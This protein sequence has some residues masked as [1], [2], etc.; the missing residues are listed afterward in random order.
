MSMDNL[1]NKKVLF[2]FCSVTST[3]FVG[4]C[5]YLQFIVKL[6]FIEVFNIIYNFTKIIK[7]IIKTCVLT[8]VIT[9]I[10]YVIIVL[11]GAPVLT[12]CN[13]TLILAL[14]LTTLTLVPACLH[15]GTDNLLTLFINS[16]QLTEE[17]FLEA[18]KLNIKIVLITT[19]LSAFVLALDWD[20]KWQIWPTP[21]I[22]GA[23]LGYFISHFLTFIKILKIK[24]EKKCKKK[25]MFK[26]C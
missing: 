2:F 7:E 8:V 13:E 15:L 12:H 23:L 17:K 1:Q 21:C 10:Y 26:T 9:I 19:W 24:L 6:V 4:I 5:L 22:I 3:Y 18:I 20:R 25:E 16:E 11:Y 14:T